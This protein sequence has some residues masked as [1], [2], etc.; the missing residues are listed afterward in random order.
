MGGLKLTLEIDPSDGTPEQIEVLFKNVGRPLT[1]VFRLF[2]GDMRQEV[3]KTFDAEGQLKKWKKSK[4]ASDSGGKTL[5][6]SGQLYRSINYRA[7][8][9]ELI[10]GSA[11]KRAALHFFGGTV[12]PKKAKSL[13]IPWDESVKLSPRDYEDTFIAKG[14]IFQTQGD[15]IV[16]L[17]SL[18]KK[19]V[20]PAR[21][22]IEY[23]PRARR[24]LFDRIIT[25]YTE[26]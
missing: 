19:V 18:R 11:D 4:R 17:F 6:K 15:K 21:R 22:F 2:E 10:I 13:A 9:D 25:H 8:D 3:H 1:R 26:N 16:P 20:I 7:T 14:V 12:R 24:K 5:R 23:T